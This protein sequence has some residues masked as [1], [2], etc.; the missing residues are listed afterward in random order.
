[1][2]HLN[3]E[4]GNARLAWSE[5]AERVKVA[6]LTVAG[7]LLAC[8]LYAALGLAVGDMHFRG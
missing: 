1:M 5:I 2:T 6:A 4:I 3:H 7:I 8:Y